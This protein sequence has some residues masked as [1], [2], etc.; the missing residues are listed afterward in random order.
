MGKRRAGRGGK[1]TGPAQSEQSR[2]RK[3]TEDPSI[4]STG[5][6]QPPKKSRPDAE[7]SPASQDEGTSSEAVE[8]HMEEAT[9]G[10]GQ[11]K[12]H[13]IGL[14]PESSS[15]PAITKELAHSFDLRI[16]SIISSSQIQKK[17]KGVLELLSTSVNDNK[18]SKS[19]IV[20]LHSKAAPASKL[21][22]IAEIAKRELGKEGGVWYQ[23]SVIGELMT[24][25]KEN[26][27]KKSSGSPPWKNT[28]EEEESM[29][30]DGEADEESFETMK[31][32]FERAI[33]GKPKIRVAPTLTIY[34]SK[35]RIEKLRDL[36]G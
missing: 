22:T 11:S 35:V 18:S 2:K 31:T 20:V 5:P 28:V 30:L 33:E 8:E 10:A 36:Y 27:T 29:N 24:E 15:L 4:T 23:Y 32:P 1:V 13:I 3:N 25:R 34:L 12:E 26:G 9:I 21:I 17:V 19:Q 7:V 16:T 14:S 6:S